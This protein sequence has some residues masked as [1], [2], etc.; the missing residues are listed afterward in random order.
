MKVLHIVRH[1]F[2]PE[3]WM[4]SFCS[5]YFAILSDAGLDTKNVL[6]LE[7][8]Q[9]KDLR[10]TSLGDQEDKNSGLWWQRMFTFGDMLSP[11]REKA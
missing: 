3:I 4:H 7:N 6:L 1:K 5:Y 9:Y 11:L 2:A 10:K 8:K